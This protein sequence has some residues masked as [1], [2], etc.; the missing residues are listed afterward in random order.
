[1]TRPAIDWP[2]KA[3]G[4]D[5]ARYAVASWVGGWWRLLCAHGYATRLDLISFPGAKGQP[6]S[7]AERPEYAVC[8]ARCR[9]V[10]HGGLL[11]PCRRF[12]RWLRQGLDWPKLRGNWLFRDHG[13]FLRIT[14]Q[15][16]LRPTDFKRLITRRQSEA[17]EQEA[18]CL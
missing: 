8:P 18:K 13:H 9:G 7:H 15:Y 12:L 10:I 2:A 4:R 14:A 1:M 5:E 17:S 16:R 11:P 6:E 3:D